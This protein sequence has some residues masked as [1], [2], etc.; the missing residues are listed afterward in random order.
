MAD[1]IR[2]VVF[3]ACF[4]PAQAEA[5]TQHVEAAIGMQDAIGDEAARLFAAQ[6][7]SAIGFG[8]SLAEAFGQ[9]VAR[10]QLEGMGEETTPQLFVREGVDPHTMIL[11]RPPHSEWTVFAAPNEA[12]IRTFGE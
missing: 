3:N 5:V 7:Y 11:V 1:N 6:F 2:L 12:A 8:R 10:L 9:A 4:T